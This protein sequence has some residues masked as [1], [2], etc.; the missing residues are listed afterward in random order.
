MK[1]PA[2]IVMSATAHARSIYFQ[3]PL[4]WETCPQLLDNSLC[5]T[6][7]GFWQFFSSG[8]LV[9]IMLLDSSRC[10][11]Y[12]GTRLRQFGQQA[13]ILKQDECWKDGSDFA[14]LYFYFLNLWKSIQYML[15]TYQNVHVCIYGTCQQGVRI[16]GVETL[17]QPKFLCLYLWVVASYTHLV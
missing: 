12:F 13:K 16:G 10:A 1:P 17:L 14:H 5:K 4:F 9:K 8:I 3:S 15:A 2:H 6:Y 7:F 11:V